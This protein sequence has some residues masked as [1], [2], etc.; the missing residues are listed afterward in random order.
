MTGARSAIALAAVIIALGSP[1][2]VAAGAGQRPA[3]GGL[4]TSPTALAGYAWSDDTTGFYSYDS[5]G[6]AVTLEGDGTGAYFAFFPGL[7]RLANSHVD[8]ST[9]GAGAACLLVH[10]QRLG[11]NLVIAVGCYSPSG[12]PANSEFD[13][14]VTA[15]RRPPRGVFDYV[16]VPASRSGNLTGDGQYN[17]A[18]KA[19]SVRH[20]STGRYEI[21]MP[22]PAT[23]GVTGTV[24]VTNVDKGI[25][26]GCELAGWHGTRTGQVIKVSCFSFT[27]ARQNRSFGVSY[28]RSGN[29]LGIGR[30]T[31][32]YAFASRPA[33]STYQ[34]RD[35]YD[36]SHGARVRVFRQSLGSYL[37]EPVGSGGPST[38][39]GGDAQVSAVG[40]ADG[41]CYV[42]GW[43][44]GTTPRI[45]VGCVNRHGA[46]TDSAFT[47]QWT[48]G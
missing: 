27:G 23:S 36:S 19:N 38:V 48:V 32:A 8:V 5:T 13:V 10:A 15:P 31:S 2:A 4:A 35:Q 3:E 40:S 41:R 6:H 33:A 47:I 9:Y 44:N 17:S 12:V 14:A 29:L 21:A 28:V 30:V 25:P 34:P 45:H 22:G 43:L 7:Q 16:L 39:N 20:L 26:G 11:P 18:R 37:V 42:V 24:Q 1:A 46:L